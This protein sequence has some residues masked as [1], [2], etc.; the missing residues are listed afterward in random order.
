MLVVGR[1]SRYN[2]PINPELREK[3]YL[4]SKGLLE[5]MN[6]ELREKGY[7]PSKGLLE[8]S[9]ARVI[10]KT[11]L[12]KQWRGECFRD[13]HIPTAASVSNTAE[14]DALRSRLIRNSSR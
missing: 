1:N 5:P 14:T 11:L 7:L 10:Y 9:L 12:L 4:P 6:S 8:P 13:N 3:G 2:G